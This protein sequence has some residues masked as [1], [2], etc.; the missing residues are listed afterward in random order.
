VVQLPSI[1]VSNSYST[2]AV[3]PQKSEVSR[4]TNANTGLYVVPASKKS[5][6]TGMMILDTVGADATYA[7]AVKKGA[8]F[9]PLD[10]FVAAGGVSRVNNEITMVAAEIFTNV[11][12]AGSTN[13]TVDMAAQVQ[14]ISV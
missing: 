7:L 5:K 10:V 4:V 13:G 3:I 8:T 1:G 2:V 14:E 6:V 12:D 11:G 9:F